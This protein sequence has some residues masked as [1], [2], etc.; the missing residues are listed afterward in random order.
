MYK[1]V[2]SVVL[3]MFL[4]AIAALL[5]YYSIY[6]PASITQT[7]SEKVDTSG[8]V[9]LEKYGLGRGSIPPDFTI[10]A[11]GKSITL[12]DFAKQQ[13][14]ILVYFMAT[15]CPFC[16]ED[17]KELSKVYKDYEN[18]IAFLSISIDPQEDAAILE[19]YKK[20]Y[21]ELQSMMF[22]PG[23][24]GI[25]KDYYVTKTTTKYGINKD[26]KIVYSG[27]GALEEDEWRKLLDLMID[28]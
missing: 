2:S 11:E 23:K 6:L 9:S 10:T 20:K 7:K 12:S 5:T 24:A 28:S 13:K 1:N 21:P 14:P 26:G 19:E 22:A 3:F 16:A 15:W 25:L 17:Y 18:R 27:Y 8:P 4:I